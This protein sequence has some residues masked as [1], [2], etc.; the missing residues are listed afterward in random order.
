MPTAVTGGS[1][2][3]ERGQSAA[4]GRGT[5]QQ[6]TDREP[7]PNREDDSAERLI[8]ES[9]RLAPRSN[10]AFCASVSNPARHAASG[11]LSSSLADL[12]GSGYSPTITAPSSFAR[13]SSRIC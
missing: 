12:P 1:P 11:R 13:A 5:S 10:Q 6:L 7:P 3:L 2:S 9:I 8:G 4:E